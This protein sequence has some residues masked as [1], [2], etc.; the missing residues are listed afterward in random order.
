MN[1]KINW[2]DIEFTDILSRASAYAIVWNGVYKGKKVAIKMVQLK[3]GIYWDKENSICAKGESGKKISNKYK[4]IFKSDDGIPFAHFE[5]MDHRPVSINR[6]E[7]EAESLYKYGNKYKIAP[8]Y[9]GQTIKE[10]DNGIH[11]GFLVMELMDCSM[12]DIIVKRDFTENEE[13]IIKKLINKM[14]RKYECVHR[15]L[16]PSNIC[17]L[18]DS[19]GEVYKVKLI[20]FQSMAS[21]GKIGKSEFNSCVKN[22]WENYNYRKGVNI[23]SRNRAKK[24]C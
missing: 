4:K 17:G 3:T 8:K 16:K 13:K 22:D 2:S 6:F 5:F 11:Y 1:K 9:Y 12:K 14:H 15:D 24:I 23:E 20:D 18:L 21:I 10:M 7:N 19:N